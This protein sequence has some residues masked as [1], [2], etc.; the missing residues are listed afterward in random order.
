[1]S[2]LLELIGKTVVLYI[3]VTTAMRFMGKRQLGEMSA[4]EI[5]VALMISEVAAVPISDLDVPLWHGLVGVAI[6]ALLEILVAYADL[7]IPAFSGIM[8]GKPTIV[9]QNGKIMEKELVKTRLT[10]SELSELLRLK[11]TKLKDVY[12]AIIER[13]GQL[14]I[15]PNNEASGVTRQDMSI[16][17]KEAPLDFA[18]V[19]DGKINYQNLALIKKDSVFIDKILSE[20]RVKNVKDVLILC[21]D[22][23]GATFFQ[24]KG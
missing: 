24:R 17:I 23:N 5:I 21:A 12:M 6:L 16:S 15:I 14:S 19:I 20:R 13:N 4:P 11:N 18:V 7:K 10:I 3:T 1:M 8:Q 2:E 22:K 9:V